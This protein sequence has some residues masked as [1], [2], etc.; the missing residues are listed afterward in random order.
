M[1]KEYGEW[2]EQ[3]GGA[4]GH[5]RVVERLRSDRPRLQQGSK[6]NPGY[7]GSGGNNMRV[8]VDRGDNRD[9]DSFTAPRASTRF[10]CRCRFCSTPSTRARPC[11]S[12][13]GSWR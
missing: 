8:R 3:V 7:G 1:E 2:K 6:T 9:A 13:A 11:S 12:H 10:A 4:G 5:G